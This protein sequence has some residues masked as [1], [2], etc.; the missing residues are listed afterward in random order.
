MAELWSLKPLCRWCFDLLPQKVD[1]P[2][3]SDFI[4]TN[5]HIGIK[6]QKNVIS[7][8]IIKH[9]LTYIELCE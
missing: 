4:S 3:S 1:L 6:I 8:S 5:I 2:C 7:Y 9:K